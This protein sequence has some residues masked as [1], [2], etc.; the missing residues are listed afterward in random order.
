MQCRKTPGIPQLF[1]LS[2]WN[3]PQICFE[4]NGH[5][6]L[7]LTFFS[8]LSAVPITQVAPKNSV[9]IESDQKLDIPLRNFSWI[10]TIV[11]NCEKSEIFEVKIA[12]K[13]YK[14]QQYPQTLQR[15]IYIFILHLHSLWTY[16][17]LIC[18]KPAL[19]FSW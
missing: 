13:H 7:Y 12:F 5:G 4:K 8:K 11:C 1:L 17:I 16:K 3:F 6:R 10:I 15:Y 2:W 14:I 18:I 9:A 19:K